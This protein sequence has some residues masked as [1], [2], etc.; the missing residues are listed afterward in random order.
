[1]SQRNELL[2]E[3]SVMNSHFRTEHGAFESAEMKMPLLNRQTRELQPG[4]L[5]LIF[6]CENSTLPH[7][8]PAAK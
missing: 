8:T 3:C 4:G 7:F 1:M 2:H 6:V 5:K